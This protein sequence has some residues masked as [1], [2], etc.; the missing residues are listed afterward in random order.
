MATWATTR[1]EVGLEHDALGPPG[2]VGGQFFEL[3][4]GQQLVEQLVDT[5]VLLCRHLD[6]DGVATPRLGHQFVLGELGQHS[7]GVGVVLVD[8]VD[9]DDDR[10]IG[11][12][13]VVDGLDRL[14]H[15]AVVGGNDQHDDVG[16]L[17][18]AGAHLGERGVTGGVDEGD[19]AAVALDHVGAD[20]LGDATGLAG[21]DVGVADAVE[22]RG[23]A[24]VDV[25]HHGD[26]WSARRLQRLVVVVAVV[27]HRL[28]FELFLLA[29][30]DEQDLGA[31]LEGEQLHLLVGQRHGGRDHLAVLQQEADDVGRGAVQLRSELLR[32][33]AALDD[34]G[35]LGNRGV[36]GRVVGVV[37]RL[38]IVEVTTTTSTTL[39]AGRAALTIR[40]R[41]AATWTRTTGTAAGA[42]ARP[43][44]AG[45]R[46]AEAAT[47]TLRTECR[48]GATWACRTW[49]AGAGSRAAGSTGSSTEAATGTRSAEAGGASAGGSGRTKTAGGR[50]NGSA[51]R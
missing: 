14:R 34:D 15:D 31:D 45:T 4:N 51:R 43:T 37:R 50:W 44:G 20:V 35:A 30:L 38:H 23:L 18:A 9:G 22:Q 19:L 27:E 7:T 8:L 46:A 32:R 12:L 21:D 39:L 17:G 6:D 47:W 48:T 28:Q 11:G 42:A 2:R 33:H 16:D 13:G 5:D 29:G 36:G 49:T 26:H 25:T 1:V 24:V 3:G 10:H 40:T 41:A